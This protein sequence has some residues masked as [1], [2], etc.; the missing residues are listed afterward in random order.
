M[1]MHVVF[2]YYTFEYPNIFRIA[3]LDDQIAAPH[4][5]LSLQHVVSV[6]CHPNY[7]YCESRN[8]MAV[9]AIV[10]H[11]QTSNTRRDV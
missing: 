8:A 3:D 2:T 6:L 5:N 10:L 11:S 7:V 9:V 1:H 4:F